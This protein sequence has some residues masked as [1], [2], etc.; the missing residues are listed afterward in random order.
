MRKALLAT[1]SLGIG[2]AETHIVELALELKNR[3]I[4]VSVASNGGVYASALEAAGI[5]HHTVPLHRRRPL[6]MIKSYI[7]LRGIIKRESPD[8]VHAHARIPGFICGLLNKKRRFGFVA[9]AHWVFDASG[10]LRRLTNWGSKTIAVSDDIK[11]Y[12]ID[13]YGIPD[14]DIFVTINAVDTDK[15]SPVISPDAVM[16]EFSLDPGRPVICNVG[17]LDDNAAAATRALIAIAPRLRESIAGV[18]LLIAGDGD[19]Y[20]QLKAQ[21]E[22]VNRLT[23]ER[24]VI[25]T[26]A[27]TDINR[28]LAA[29]DLFVGS[30]RAALEA[31]AAG[32][33]VIAAG[34]EGFIGLFTPEKKAA[35]IETNFCFRG[36]ELMTP[37]S[38]A[39][40]ILGFFEKTGSDERK[41]LGEYGRELVKSEY[42][43]GRMTDDCLRAYEAALRPKYGIVVSG[44]YGFKNAGDEAILQSIC[45]NIKETR[46]D[47]SI[48][49]LSSD[50]SDTEERYGIKAIARFNIFRVYKALRSCDVL[51]SGGGSLLQDATSTRSLMYYLLI[52]K[53]ARMLGKKVML[54]ANGIGPVRG[55]A[56][57]RRVRRVV[58]RSDAITLRDGESE[59]ELRSMGIARDDIRVTADPVFALCGLPRD[60]S[61]RLLESQGIPGGPFVAVA[62]RDWPGGGDF[63]EKIAAACDG[64]HE[65]TG[66]HAVFI[67]MQA[68]QDAKVAEKARGMMRTPSYCLGGRLSA[69]ELIGVIGVSSAMLAMRLHALI[70]A[71]CM[72]VPFASLV[73]DP[74]ISSFTRSLGMPIIGDVA[75]FDAEHAAETVA[76]LME[77]RDEHAEALRGK[78]AQFKEAAKENAHLLL[79]L[80]EKET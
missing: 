60:E 44:Y 9:T 49:V 2:G 57:R 51:I 7:L 73:Y 23:G 31:M 3:G 28:I 21:A 29:C 62:I 36:C 34:K 15:F 76:R 13:N 59:D 41:R 16:A 39:R 42:S 30:S 71:A 78:T 22:A 74:K 11:Q 24:T 38:L 79:S 17:R 72:N 8:I 52:I 69:E 35:A 19:I 12:L 67:P 68:D 65:R 26:G 80:L 66:S 61:R 32:K 10:I 46:V 54:Y 77:R 53:A 20:E 43:V 45:A 33:P 70:F 47:A 37:D 1:M 5:A 48:S 27:R 58:D 64:I 63:C 56:N 40:E 75:S 18:Q 25:L 4:D 14:D 50:P 55:K 6:S